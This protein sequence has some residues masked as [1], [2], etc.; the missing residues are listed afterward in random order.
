M[1]EILN[2]LKDFFKYDAVV[3]PFFSD[4]ENDRRALIV[5]IRVHTSTVDL[6]DRERETDSKYQHFNLTSI[7]LNMADLYLILYRSRYL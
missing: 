4:T 3:L 5:V 2:Q 7:I 6:Y 1:K